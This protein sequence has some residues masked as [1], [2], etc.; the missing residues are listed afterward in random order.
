MSMSIEN[1]DTLS[2]LKRALNEVD[3]DLTPAGRTFGMASD[4]G[5]AILGIRPSTIH[6]HAC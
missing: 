3:D 4:E 6:L 2:I 1:A 5:R